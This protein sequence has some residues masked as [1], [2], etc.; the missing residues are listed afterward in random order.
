M[1]RFLVV[2][3]FTTVLLASEMISIDSLRQ[4]TR[5]SVFKAFKKRIETRRV[6]TFHRNFTDRLRNAKSSMR[7]S[8]SSGDRQRPTERF[9]APNSQRDSRD[10]IERQREQE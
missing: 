7:S 8:R 10:M 3:F 1:K 5:S 6:S 4:E 2:I 9:E